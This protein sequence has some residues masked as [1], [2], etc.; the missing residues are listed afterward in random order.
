M[1][2]NNEQTFDRVR[3]RRAQSA[4]NPSS[5]TAETAPD[6]EGKRVLFSE[7][8]TT[9]ASGKVALTCRRCEDRTVVSWARALRLALPSVPAVVP[10]QGVRNY[11]R[12]PSCG[13]RS[14]ITVS[15]RS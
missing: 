2:A 14:W 12:C 11:M 15:V 1:G 10:G 9:P 7:V 5:G 3:P 8:P 13:Q 6:R 4:R